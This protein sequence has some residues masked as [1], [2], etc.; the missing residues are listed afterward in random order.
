MITNSNQGRIFCIGRNYQDHINELSNQRP[1]EPV[2][3]I[4]P[5]SCR[6]LPGTSIRYPKHGHDL[7]HEV[8]IV[9][10]IGKSGSV[11]AL[12]D[13]TRFI[14]GVTVGLDL[15]LR[16]VQSDLKNKGL[17]W[18]KAKSFDGSAPMGEFVPYNPE[19]DLTSISFGCRINGQEKQAGNTAEMLFSI[20]ELVLAISAIWKLNSSDLIFTGTPAGVGPLTVG[21]EIEIFSSITPT[22][23]WN[24]IN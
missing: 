23:Y 22:F 16:D 15:T 24:V 2:I 14:S 19:I 5:A 6:V 18:E 7:Q 8:E 13:A 9:V 1:A 4:K 20:P 11:R 3:F 12:E 10:Q 21:D 17:P